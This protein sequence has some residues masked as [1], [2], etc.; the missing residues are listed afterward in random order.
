MHSDKH[1]QKIDDIRA[2][3]HDIPSNGKH[4]LQLPEYSAANDKNQVIQ[5]G[6]TDD[7]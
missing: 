3:I 4:V 7:T 2:V 6:T 1:V 5:D